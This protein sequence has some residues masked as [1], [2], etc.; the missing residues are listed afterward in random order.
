[1]LK[2]MK[3]CNWFILFFIISVQTFA[4]SFSVVVKEKQ[5]N[6]GQIVKINYKECP[7]EWLVPGVLGIYEIV[8]NIK[9]VTSEEQQISINVWD[10]IKDGVLQVCAFGKCVPI[11]DNSS[12]Y[13]ATGIARAGETPADIHLSYGSTKPNSDL[14][15][16]FHVRIS[17]IVS[18]IQFTV[19]VNI[20]SYADVDEIVDEGH[21]NLVYYYKQKYVNGDI[22]QD[23]IVSIEDVTLLVN[24]LTG[25]SPISTP[26]SLLEGKWKAKDGES[27]SFNS[28][29]TIVYHNASTF[30]YRA[31][32]KLILIYDT[33]NSL[34][35]AFD[36]LD[37]ND[38]YL[39]LKAVGKND[40]AKVYY[41]T[42]LQLP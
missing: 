7:V 18:S 22:N 13:T 16:I 9:I 8:P 21:G 19:Q 42:L 40:S 10:E 30:K 4:Q 37:A 32:D 15:R 23:G 26:E 27:L 17:N 39:I 6:N 36:V 28:D 3:I 35:E 11:T 12:P 20:G 41:N 38:A 1:M 29:G 2:I 31:A 24:M 5:V 25:K 33:S 34:Q 14:Q